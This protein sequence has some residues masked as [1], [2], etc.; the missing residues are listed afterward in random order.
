MKTMK[1]N[2]NSLTISVILNWGVVFTSIIIGTVI[3]M[4]TIM[5]FDMGLGIFI[6]SPLWGFCI[7]LPFFIHFA[8]KAEHYEKVLKN[9]RLELHR[10]RRAAARERYLAAK[11]EKDENN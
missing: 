3:S 9:E 1:K 8:A 11:L 6:L 5:H 4:L 7:S 10:A 2:I